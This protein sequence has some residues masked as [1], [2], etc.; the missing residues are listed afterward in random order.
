MSTPSAPPPLGGCRT[1]SVA[2]W[3]IRC[4]R[5][6]G[7]TFAAK[8]LAKMGVGC[9]ILSEMK[10][11]NDRYTRMTSGYKVLSTKAPSKNQGGIALLWQPDHEGFEVEATQVVTPNLITFQLVTGDEQYYA[12]GTY[13]PPTTRGGEAT[14]FGR[15]GKHARPTAAPSSWATST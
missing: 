10:I 7:L 3:N 15:L 9:A 6:N 8:G 5:G 2:A 1:F 13:L 12:M 11:T 14:T 4:G